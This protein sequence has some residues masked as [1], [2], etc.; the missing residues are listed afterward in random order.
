MSE[1]NYII[2]FEIRANGKVEARNVEFTSINLLSLETAILDVNVND[3]T[4]LCLPKS[5]FEVAGYSI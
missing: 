4:R 5:G 1:L 3:A 2:N